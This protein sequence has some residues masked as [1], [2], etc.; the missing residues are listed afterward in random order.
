MNNP[1]VSIVLTTYNRRAILPRAVDSVLRGGHADFELLVVDD[2]SSD[3]TAEYV[4]QIGDP[5]VRYIRFEENGGVL[6]SRNRGFD[7]AR[8]EYVAILDDDDELTPDALQAIVEGFTAP[9]NADIGILWFDCMDAESG[10]AS[11]AMA[12]AGGVLDFEDYLCGRIQGDFW[13]VFRRSALAGY[14]FDERLKAHESLLWLRMHQAHR[15]RHLPRMLC[16]KY[17]RHGGPRLCDVDVRMGQLRETT[18]AMRQFVEEFGA[19][20]E[21]M[22]PRTLGGKLAYLGLHQMAIGEFAAGRASIRRSLRHRWSL[23]YAA[24]GAA[25][26]FLGAGFVRSIIRRMEA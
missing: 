4:R 20:L 18:M 26:W 10:E 16:R 15:A 17:R 12:A 7:E 19:Q 8:G 23:K 11:G 5:R 3:G 9:D 2:A 13:L 1:L 6:R 22:C 14:R 21:R 24:F 25:S